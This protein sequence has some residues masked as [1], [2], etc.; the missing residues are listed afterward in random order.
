VRGLLTNS[1]GRPNLNKT[2]GEGCIFSQKSIPREVGEPPNRNLR[3]S[4]STTVSSARLAGTPAATLPIVPEKY[5]NP[6]LTHWLN[7]NRNVQ[8]DSR[9]RN[10]QNTKNDRNRTADEERPSAGYAAWPSATASRL[11]A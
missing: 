10:F 7:L 11:P 1:E 6:A 5:A 4:L 8:H 2:N 9:C 3:E